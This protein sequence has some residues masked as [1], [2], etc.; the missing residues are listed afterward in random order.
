MEAG[1]IHGITAD[2]TA[3]GTTHG[4]TEDITE[5]TG[6][7]MTLGTTTITTTDGTTRIGDITMVRDIS[8]DRNIARMYGMVQGIRPVQTEYSAAAHL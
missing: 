7:G 8:E 6:D 1:T 2:G 3:V 5:A 4:T